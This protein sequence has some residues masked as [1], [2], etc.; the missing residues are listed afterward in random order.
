VVAQLRQVPVLR[1]LIAS[2]FTTLAYLVKHHA[3]PAGR[4]LHLQ[5]G[6]TPPAAEALVG[7]PLQGVLAF[8]LSGS[9]QLA[10]VP[11]PD[12]V[13][14]SVFQ[15]GQRDERGDDRHA[16]ERRERRPRALVLS[17]FAPGQMFGDI[18]AFAPW[19]PPAGLQLQLRAA[20]EV[21][22]LALPLEDLREFFPQ[23]VKRFT[24]LAREKASWQQGQL[25][26]ARGARPHSVQARAR[27]GLRE[28][29]PEPSAPP[30]PERR[31]PIVDVDTGGLNPAVAAGWVD[32]AKRR[33]PTSPGDHITPAASVTTSLAELQSY[34]ALQQEQ[35]A[36]VVEAAE[37]AEAVLEEEV[38]QEEE[39]AAARDA[40][41]AA[42][43]E[44]AATHAAALAAIA[45]AA[46][47]NS[48]TSAAAAAAALAASVVAEAEAEVAPMR[49]E[50]RPRPPA[51][52]RPASAPAR[53]AAA[54]PAAALVQAAEAPASWSTHLSTLP[55][56]RTSRPQS[57]RAVSADERREQAAERVATVGHLV[58]QA[59]LLAARAAPPRPSTAQPALSGPASRRASGPSSRPSSAP[60]QRAAERAVAAAAERAVAAAA[61][62]AVAAAAAA[63]AMAA[64]ANEEKEEA[65]MLD[66]MEQAG[67]AY[68]AI[69]GRDPRRERLY[70]G[71]PPGSF[72]SAATSRTRVAAAPSP[73]RIAPPSPRIA[74]PSPRIAP[75]SPRIAP[76]SPRQAAASGLDEGATAAAATRGARGKRPTTAPP[77]VPSEW[78]ARGSDRHVQR[79][80][81]ARRGRLMPRAPDE[82][83]GLREVPPWAERGGP[84]GGLSSHP[85]PPPGHIPT[86]AAGGAPAY[87][88]T[89]E[90]HDGLVDE[91]L[92][93]SADGLATHAR[94]E[95]EAARAAVTGVA[96]QDSGGYWYTP[97]A[98]WAADRRPQVMSA[99]MADSYAADLYADDSHAAART[100]ASRTPRRPPPHASGRSAGAGPRRKPKPSVWGPAGTIDSGSIAAAIYH[101]SLQRAHESSWAPPN[102]QQPPC[103]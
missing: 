95:A 88:P 31:P 35:R 63:A 26:R 72:T 57:A 89:L 21:E 13:P 79:V 19:E 12:P 34:K 9:A 45:L 44:E 66:L 30:A 16:A 73:H 54:P 50:V 6:G 29:P 42:V 18:A 82:D 74:P 87:M 60:A 97:H 59:P 39:W 5:S 103:V 83:D 20:S 91:V 68:A 76:P 32:P 55:S 85:G 3:V 28:R 67:A 65:R 8:L 27:R 101:A 84:L 33:R 99:G 47:N 36:R 92:H 69:D 78:H 17:G 40:E 10:A 70:G 25:E 56:P 7:S 64:A 81:S 14:G 43:V 75:P 90:C 96:A 48:A 80:Q 46:T 23:V 15:R 52:P 58:G 38:R 94:T 2:Q 1:G 100:A 49:V 61:E 77:R 24:R 37:A 51:S 102:T 71:N 4:L 11:S 86:A 53:P 93:L 22:L 98:A 62:R 41:E